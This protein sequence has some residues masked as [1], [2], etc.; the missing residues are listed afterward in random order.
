MTS[1]PLPRS[2]F[3]AVIFYILHI[4]HGAPLPV[5]TTSAPQINY[6]EFLLYNEVISLPDF[7][8]GMKLWKGTKRSVGE[9]GSNAR[10]MAGFFFNQAWPNSGRGGRKGVGKR[11]IRKGGKGGRGKKGWWVSLVLGPRVGLFVNYGRDLSDQKGH[12]LK[13]VF[14]AGHAILLLLFYLIFVE[15]M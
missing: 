11:R 6:Q 5:E 9:I 4:L 12:R 14:K 2:L 13:I 1:L 7:D 3:L 10:E 15:Q 8:S